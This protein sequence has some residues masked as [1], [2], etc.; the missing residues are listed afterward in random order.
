MW[1]THMGKKWK[2][3]TSS[4]LWRFRGEEAP[5]KTG[6]QLPVVVNHT[7]VVCSHTNQELNGTTLCQAKIKSTPICTTFAVDLEASHKGAFLGFLGHH[8]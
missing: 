6:K 1:D 8:S 5:H 3:S 4:A 2:Q 7:Q